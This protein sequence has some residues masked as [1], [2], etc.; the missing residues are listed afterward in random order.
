[1]ANEN[2]PINFLE[3]EQDEQAKKERVFPLHLKIN[4]YYFS[5]SFSA[6]LSWQE[7]TFPVR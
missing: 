2:I 5:V 7:V 6:I 1:M 4:Y 3:D